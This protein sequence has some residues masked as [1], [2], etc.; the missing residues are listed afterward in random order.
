MRFVNLINY[1]YEMKD[2]NAG[3]MDIIDCESRI[4]IYDVRWP[5]KQV[6]HLEF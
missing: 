2:F 4:M 5:S 6:E 1:V 3:L